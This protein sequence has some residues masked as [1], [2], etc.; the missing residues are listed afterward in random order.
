MKVHPAVWSLFLLLA[1]GIVGGAFYAFRPTTS[2][3]PS[4]AVPTTDGGRFDLA[5]E[6]GH[7]V[8]LDFFNI[9]C[10]S[11]AIVEKDLE[12]LRP[13]WNAS[14]VRVVSVGVAPANSLEELRAYARQHN[15]TWTVAQDT[16]SGVEKFGVVGLPTLA[17]IDPSGAIVFHQGGLP[18]REKIADVV[19][20]AA[21]SRAAPTAF[22]QYPLALLAVVAAVAS[23]FS[24]C[25]IG[26]LP[27]YVAHTVRFAPGGNARPMARA[28]SLGGLAALGLLLVF[29]G[30][31]G[32]AYAFGQAV[33]PYV[34]WLAPF[35]GGVFVLVGGLLLLR[36]YS[37]FLQRMF[38]PLTQMSGDA[39][40]ESRA[41]SYFLYGLGYGAGAA[42]CTAPVLL[43]IAALAASAGPLVGAG[44]VLLYGL[45]AALLMAVLT[46]VVAGG[47][48][49][50][51]T[52]IRRHAHKVEVASSL[53]FVAAGVFLLWYAWRAGTITL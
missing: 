9:Y 37:L 20:S 34:K 33:G 45:T 16:D 13:S 44:L 23:F 7:V 19:A 26:L 36:P 21:A 3:T 10:E 25:A 40:G 39:Q 11:C 28:A 35:M 53:F 43:S 2:T 31:G 14:E 32:L 38:A 18:G 50:V 22:A 8:V 46:V 41:L 6:R 51:A 15:L 49:S 42:G 4:Y 1:V 27:G 29:L 48:T 17:V 47:R 24:P 52:W 30:V 5:T 12:A